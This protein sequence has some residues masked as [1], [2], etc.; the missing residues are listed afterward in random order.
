M[1]RVITLI[2]LMLTLTT[3]SYAKCSGSSCSKSN[4]EKEECQQDKDEKKEDCQDTAEN[5]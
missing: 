4:A 2:A 3:F 5:S 1:K